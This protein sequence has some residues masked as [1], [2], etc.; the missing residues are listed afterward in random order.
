[1]IRKSTPKDKKGAVITFRLTPKYRFALELMARRQHRSVTGVV[2]WAID[3]ALQIDGI[4]HPPSKPEVLCLDNGAKV[5][6]EKFKLS[7]LDRLWSPI[8]AKR[9]VNFGRYAPNLMSFEEKLIW[10]KIQDEPIFHNN[11]GTLDGNLIKK[12]WGLLEDYGEGEDFD[13]EAFDIIAEQ[14][15][16]DKLSAANAAKNDIIP[17]D[18]DGE[19][20]ITPSDHNSVKKRPLTKP[21]RTKQ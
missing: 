14:R 6:I 13:Q 7:L 17:E 3:Q 4:G 12:A 1:M 9:L 16:K 20:V 18:D 21:L 5:D 10:D 8:E 2:E 11:D 19:E 15:Q